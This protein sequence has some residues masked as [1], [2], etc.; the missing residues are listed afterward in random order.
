M[1]N[2]APQREQ[3]A[4]QPPLNLVIPEK[5]ACSLLNTPARPLLTAQSLSATP[6]CLE[7]FPC[8]LTVTTQIVTQTFLKFVS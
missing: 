6:T 8:V 2:E 7:I 3:Q 1:R 4:I 5:A